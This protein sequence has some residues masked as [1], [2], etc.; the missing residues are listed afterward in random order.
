MIKRNKDIP[1][2]IYNFP[3]NFIAASKLISQLRYPIEIYFY[4][5]EKMLNN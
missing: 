3:N 5:G 2:I 4:F 1:M